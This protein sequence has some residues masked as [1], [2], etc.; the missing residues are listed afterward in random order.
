MVK[1]KKRVILRLQNRERPIR[2]SEGGVE[3]KRKQEAVRRKVYKK[4]FEYDGKQHR[5]IRD[6]L[7]IP[8]L[9]NYQA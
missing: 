4:F 1:Q 9:K 6:T 3:K 7:L 5:G 8:G 2:S